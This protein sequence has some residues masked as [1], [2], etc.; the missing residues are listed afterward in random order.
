MMALKALLMM[1]LLAL[2]LP[3]AAYAETAYVSDRIQAGMRPQPGREGP[4]L[5]TLSTGAVLEVLERVTGYARVRD[6]EGTEGWMDAG[7]L[8]VEPPARSQLEGMKSQLSVLKAQVDKAQAS[9]A[10][11]AAKSAQLARRLE[12]KTA[13]EGMAGEA[14]APS[15]SPAMPPATPPSAL[16]APSDGRSMAKHPWF[17]PG[18]G[19]FS[20][21]MLV[22][23]FFAGVLWLR[24]VNR[25]KLGGLHLRI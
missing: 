17:S 15:Q 5:K 10:Q 3:G 20:F 7:I 9:L 21:A 6:A 2:G 18:W 4:P 24:E 23:G 13:R 25:K 12:E 1:S 11:E 8:S 16:P 14:V 22:V 19:A